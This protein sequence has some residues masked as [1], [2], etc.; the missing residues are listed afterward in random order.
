M[1]GK[2]TLLL[3]MIFIYSVSCGF[4]GMSR[5]AMDGQSR[6][7]RNIKVDSTTYMKLYRVQ[8]EFSSRREK[9]GRPPPRAVFQT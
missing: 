5:R 4:F 6:I 7:S 3:L 9:Q 1:K 8:V 2:L